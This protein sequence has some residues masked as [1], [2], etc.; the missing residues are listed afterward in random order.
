MENI[1]IMLDD[2]N[3]LKFSVSIQGTRPG[4][5]FCR[6]TIEGKNMSFT[7]FVQTNQLK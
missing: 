1:D 7:I 5:A 3:E 6:Y 4:N 2:D